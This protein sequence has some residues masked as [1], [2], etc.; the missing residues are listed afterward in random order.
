M[1]HSV[2]TIPVSCL[3]NCNE[4][5]GGLL[6]KLATVIR[7]LI[8]IRKRLGYTQY[9][10]HSPSHLS[11]QKYV[12]WPL[13]TI[14]FIPNS[15]ICLRDSIPDQNEEHLIIAKPVGPYLSIKISFHFPED[16]GSL[17]L[18]Y[19]LARREI[20]ILSRLR[21]PSPP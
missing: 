3:L 18:K 9:R 5:L 13:P 8:E 4:I 19:H 21:T 7:G 1:C 17:N 12:S 15:T 2:N 16:V 10:A 11:S 14:M 6:K 20:F